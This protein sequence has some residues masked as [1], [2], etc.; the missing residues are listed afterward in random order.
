ML[1]LSN[2]GLRREDWVLRNVSFN[3]GQGE[4]VGI[5]GK[6]GVGKTTLLKLMCG[7]LD[8]SEGKV[9]FE[10]KELKGP[11]VK[12]IP[13]YEELQLVNQDFALDLYHS[14][15]E[16]LREKVLHLHKEDQTFLV[17]ELLTLLELDNIRGRKAHLLSGGEQQRLALGRAIACEPKCILLDEPFV[18]LDFRLRLK[19]T[20]YLLELN[21]V[22][23]TTIILVSHD[24]EEIM[25]IADKII[26]VNQE[27]IVEHSNP[28]SFFYQPS[29]KEEAEL[30]GIINSLPVNGEEVFFRPNEYDLEGEQFQI[31]YL[32]S[33]NTGMQIMNYFS[34]LMIKQEK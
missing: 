17:E 8:L 20:N 11:S 7:L 27:G 9:H 30:L 34:A 33:I 22:R 6:S 21:N 23:N 19:I 10:E 5:V 29:S 26:Y 25:S 15:E 13:G 24:G 1:R 4:L 28:L 2:L 12:L 16:N 3:V 31:K 32:R 18:H 14:V